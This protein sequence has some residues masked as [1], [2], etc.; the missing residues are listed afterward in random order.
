MLWPIEIGVE[1]I[2]PS[3]AKQNPVRAS[4]IDD[5]RAIQRRRMAVVV[6]IRR[7][8]RRQNAL[9]ARTSKVEAPEFPPGVQVQRVQVAVVTR[10][11]HVFAD[12]HRA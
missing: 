11:Y 6:G 2:G 5:A 7:I 9:V 4:Y 3:V 12:D 10:E 1:R 8:D